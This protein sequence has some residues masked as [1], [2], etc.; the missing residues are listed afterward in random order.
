MRS[1]MK[2]KKHTEKKEGEKKEGAEKK[3][4]LLR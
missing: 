4:R 3:V 1:T 2:A